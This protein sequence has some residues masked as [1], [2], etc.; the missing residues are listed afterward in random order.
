MQVAGCQLGEYS[1]QRTVSSGYIHSLA[2]STS[3]D[4]ASSHSISPVSLLTLRSPAATGPDGTVGVGALSGGPLSGLVLWSVVLGL[5]D[6]VLPEGLGEGV[7]LEGLGDGSLPSLGDGSPPVGA[8]LL[9]PSAAP[10]SP[11]YRFM[12]FLNVT[13][14]SQTMHRRVATTCTIDATRATILQTVIG[15]ESRAASCRS[16]ERGAHRADIGSSSH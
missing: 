3:G 13:L 2:P 9:L 10:S 5:G 14:V 11:R 12:L 7:P 16:T 15:I 6:G 8:G 1:R 4:F